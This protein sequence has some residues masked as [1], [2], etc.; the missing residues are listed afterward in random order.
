MRAGPR[1]LPK[2]SP[3]LIGPLSKTDLSLIRRRAFP[4]LDPP[5]GMLFDPLLTF[6]LTLPHAIERHLQAS[7][8]FGCYLQVNVFAL[9]GG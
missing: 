2:E 9:G 4:A 8:E 1:A 7:T 5:T 3:P 6:Y